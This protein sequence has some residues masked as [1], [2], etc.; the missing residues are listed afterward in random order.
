MACT[1]TQ[2]GTWI[3]LKIDRFGWILVA[4]CFIV[5]T[6]PLLMFDPDE[7]GLILGLSSQEILRYAFQS[8]AVAF[9]V[10]MIFALLTLLLVALASK[11]AVE[12]ETKPEGTAK[13]FLGL[14]I[15]LLVISGSLLCYLK[16]GQPGLH[17]ERLFII[18]KSQAD[19][20]SID[21]HAAVGQRRQAVY[22][23][24]VEHSLATQQQLRQRLDDFGVPYTSY[25]LVNAIETSDSP[26]LRLWL[27]S[28]PEVDRLLQSP[29]L[30]PLPEPLLAPSASTP[31]D[32]PQD[33]PVNITQIHADRVW[34]ELEYHWPGD[35]SR[36]CRQ[37]RAG[38]SPKSR[39]QLSWCWRSG[40]LQLA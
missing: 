12:V 37:R 18:L 4:M 30:R 11:S 23:R 35:F 22:D 10:I 29:R 26:L 6:L 13:K 14:N 20:G 1:G 28:R 25:Y 40:R 21:P 39:C 27:L 19:L 36:K 5:L 3:K 15:L 24:L 17:G 34:R 38:R 32:P 9:L 31:H 33:P 16:F 7:L 2:T 8:T